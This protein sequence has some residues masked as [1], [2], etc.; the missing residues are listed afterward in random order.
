MYINFK[1]KVKMEGYDEESFYKQK[2]RVQVK[3][4]R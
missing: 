1:G 3:G 2:S 4:R